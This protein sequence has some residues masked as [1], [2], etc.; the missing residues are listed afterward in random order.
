MTGAPGVGS[1]RAVESLRNGVPSGAVVSAMG[2]AHAGQLR[3]FDAILANAR[4]GSGEG[5]AMVVGE[6]GTGKS[7]LLGFF[8]QRALDANFVVSRVVISKETPLFQPDRVLAAALRDGR[9]PGARG[10]VLHELA[11]RLDFRSPATTPLAQWAASVPGML[12]ASLYLYDHAVELADDELLARVVDWWSGEKLAPAEVKAAL[13]KLKAQQAFDVKAIKVA[14]LVPHRIALVS[15]V[16]RAAGF[17]GWLILLD[18]VELVGR[19]SRLQRARSYAELARWS[20]TVGT[21]GPTIACVAAV[22]GDFSA[23][24]LD[25]GTDGLG[26]R[27][28]IPAFL[29][30]RGRPGDAELL[31]LVEAGIEALDDPAAIYLAGPD[32]QTL[33]HTYGRVADVYESAFDWAPPRRVPS[34]LNLTTPMRTYIKTWIYEWDLARLGVTSR[35]SV[36]AEAMPTSYEEDTE[37]EAVTDPSE[38]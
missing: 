18:E 22:T 23:K 9:V 7:H 17:A 16:I 38:E 8:E 28:R 15:H 32:R 31:A 11:P 37:L 5:G 4:Q 29:R 33:E 1:R 25:G 27:E 19:Y 30:T 12:A 20:G 10:A 36:E 21:N 13:R 34:L 14:D 2:W 26:D 3:Q 6:F 35:P 24:V